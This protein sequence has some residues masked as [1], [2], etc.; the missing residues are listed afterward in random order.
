MGIWASGGEFGRHSTGGRR[1][2]RIHRHGG[3]RIVRARRQNGLR[4]LDQSWRLQG[5]EA[6]TRQGDRIFL[7]EA[8]LLGR[9]VQPPATAEKVMTQDGVSPTQLWLGRL[10]GE[11]EREPLPGFLGQDTYVR[12]YLPI[13][14]AKD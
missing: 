4:A 9:V 13:P 1:G 6:G 2:A 11:G 14:R 7:P 10:P 8:I 3:R 12:I 5:I